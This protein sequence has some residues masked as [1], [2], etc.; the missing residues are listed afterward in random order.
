M[1]ERCSLH[2]MNDVRGAVT[3]TVQKFKQPD[4]TG[5]NRCLPCTILNTTI[6]A[7]MAGAVAL[8]SLSVAAALFAL[9][10]VVI[11]FRG[12]L[13]PG[14]PTLVQYLP[15]WVHEQIGPGH[16]LDGVGADVDVETTLKTADIVID[17]TDVDD[18]C[19]T[20]SYRDAWH[21]RM[22]ELTDESTQRERLADSLS[23]SAD[24]IAFEQSETGWHVKIEGVK[25]GRWQSEA[26][27][28][29]DLA[30][31]ELLASRIRQWD[32]LAADDRTQLLVSLRS[33]IEECPTC[34]GDVVPDE[35]VRKSC[36]RDD[37]VSVTTSCVECEAVL[38][39][40]TE[41]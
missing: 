34:G 17:C 8:V 41:V 29:A 21:A 10:L 15:A 38:F 12:Y 14:T 30:S 40:G 4:Y 27:F 36:C 2:H 18:L 24:E 11:F 31:E 6:A 5:E 3:A 13:V 32:A 19:L 35:E 1:I 16:E 9:S 7:V 23:V 33:F 28:V 25:A 39:K 22:A 37:I 20:E 26:A